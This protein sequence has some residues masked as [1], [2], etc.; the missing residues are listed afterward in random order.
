YLSVCCQ[1][2]VEITAVPR[3]NANTV[4]AGIVPRYIEFAADVVRFPDLTH[5]ATHRR[6]AFT[7]VHARACRGAKLG[8][9]K[10]TSV[11]RT[12]AQETSADRE[13][14]D[15]CKYTYPRPVHLQ[16]S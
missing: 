8:R 5:P 12:S 16:P 13:T 4:V 14:C 11:R 1:A 15:L 10:A 2:T 9:R 6:R 7:E 3:G